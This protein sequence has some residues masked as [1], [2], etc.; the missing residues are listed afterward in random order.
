[1][2][3]SY[4]TKCDSLGL[5]IKSLTPADRIVQK[6][7][8]VLRILSHVLNEKDLWTVG[9]KCMSPKELVFKHPHV[10][11]HTAGSSK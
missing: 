9:E 11:V 5:E 4:T 8:D 2:H 3:A 1:M 10:F 6:L 7:K